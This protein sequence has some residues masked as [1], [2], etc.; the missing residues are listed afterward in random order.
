MLDSG[1]GSDHNAINQRLNNIAQFVKLDKKDEALKEVANISQAVG[2][3][4]GHLSPD[5]NAF[6]CLCDSIDGKKVNDLSDEGIRG[7]VEI[8]SKTKAPVWQ[9]RQWLEDAKKKLIAS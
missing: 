9:F 4:I 6:I 1:I 3:I 2:F 5:F 7:Y 8:L